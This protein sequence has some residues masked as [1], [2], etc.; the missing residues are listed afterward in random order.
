M[1]EAEGPVVVDLG[2]SPRPD[3][4]SY[5]VTASF[6]APDALYKVRATAA[7]R[8]EQATLI[9]LTTVSIALVPRLAEA[10][11]AHDVRYLTAPVS[12]WSF[13]STSSR[14]AGSAASMRSRAY[15]GSVLV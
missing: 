14:W 3:Q 12:R 15:E 7:R 13:S 11:R 4:D 2:S 9:D 10:A 1:M 8:A 5:E 6:F